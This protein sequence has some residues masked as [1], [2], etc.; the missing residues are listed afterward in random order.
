MEKRRRSPPLFRA[1]RFAHQRD[2]GREGGRDA[3]RAFG[4][5]GG[6]VGWQAGGRVGGGDEGKEVK[7]MEGR[8]Q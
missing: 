6:R 7:M 5:A 4:R 3:V 1:C 2:G 8:E